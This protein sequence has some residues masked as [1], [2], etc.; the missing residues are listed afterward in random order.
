MQRIRNEKGI[1]LSVLAVT[2]IVLMILAGVTVNLGMYSVDSTKDRKLQAELEIVGQAAIT[3]YSKAIELGYI[4][5][6]TTE[7]PKNFFGTPTSNPIALPSGTWALSA[8]EAVGYK[9]Y[10][11]L[12]PQALKEL[13]ILNSVHTYIINYYTGEVYNLTEKKSSTGETLYIRMNTGNNVKKIQDTTS[14]VE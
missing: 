10:F 3:E 8:S 13:N 12:N 7:I 2:I 6:E 11:E 9:S 14:F 4:K 1:T 5:D